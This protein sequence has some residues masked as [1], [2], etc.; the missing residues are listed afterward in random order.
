MSM[1]IH[2]YEHEYTHHGTVSIMHDEFWARKMKVRRE[3]RERLLN[4]IPCALHPGRLLS[5]SILP[6]CCLRFVV[7]ASHL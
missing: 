4:L 6:H 3:L 2:M 7:S 5:C 1:H